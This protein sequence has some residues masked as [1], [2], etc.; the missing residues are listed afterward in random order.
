MPVLTLCSRY[1]DL[2]LQETTEAMAWPPQYCCHNIPYF[3]GNSEKGCLGGF[4]N[5][6][7]YRTQSRQIARGIFRVIA[8]T[9]PELVTH[10]IEGAPSPSTETWELV[11][12]D[13]SCLPLCKAGR[14]DS[15]P[16]P[17]EWL[18]PSTDPEMKGNNKNAFVFSWVGCEIADQP[19]PS[20]YTEI[21][22]GHLTCPTAPAQL[23]VCSQHVFLVIPF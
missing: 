10:W 12:P 21:T 9:D 2:C 5:S 14:L 13:S 16:T 6:L 7:S 11:P 3:K 4:T 19:H 22:P 1:P 18:S 8:C 20:P 17:G 15:E 23:A